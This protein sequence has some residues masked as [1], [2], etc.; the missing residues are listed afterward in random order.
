MGSFIYKN[1]ANI[2]SILGVLPLVLLFSEQGYLWVLPLIV[3]NNIM[4]DL[5]GILAAKLNIRSQFGA[6]IDNVCDAV[7]H[8][9]IT[10]AVCAHFGGLV[11]FAGM[12]A[13][14]AIILRATFR[15]TPTDRTIEGSATNEL[16]RHLLF[17][18]LLAELYGCSPEPYLVIAFL[19]NAVTMLI[20]FKLPFVI[21]TLANRA[22]KVVLVNIALVVA[23]LWADA[24]GLIAFVFIAG[25]LLSCWVGWSRWHRAR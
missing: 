24:T 3:F 23:W 16:M 20:P 19:A 12:I 6:N 25:Y 18:L 9:A 5:D 14:G 15:L 8:V 2:V 22:T 13:G 4:D 17:V 10:S 1:L 11:F 21:R 7:A